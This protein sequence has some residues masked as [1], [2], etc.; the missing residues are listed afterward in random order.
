M[1]IVRTYSVQRA[2]LNAFRC[3]QE[4]LCPALG[5]EN[6]T[7]TIDAVRMLSDRHAVT[8]RAPEVSVTFRGTMAVFPSDGIVRLGGDHDEPWLA[9]AIETSDEGKAAL[10]TLRPLNGT[11]VELVIRPM[12][13][14]TTTCTC[15]AATQP[16]HPHS[17]RCP[18]L[19]PLE[20]DDPR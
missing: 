4:R 11:M 3:L 2:E 14:I 8:L 20:E 13:S 17:F 10:E 18:A 7:P 19:P 12:P 16:G 9:T 5:R 6:T 1:T 15:G